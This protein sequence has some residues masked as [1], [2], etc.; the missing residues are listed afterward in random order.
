M[1]S[2]PINF[3]VLANPINWIIVILTVMIG[4]FAIHEIMPKISTNNL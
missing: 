2:I 3:G 1:D 4:S